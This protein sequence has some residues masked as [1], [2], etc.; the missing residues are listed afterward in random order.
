MKECQNCHAQVPEGQGGRDAEGRFI[1]CIHC[2][3]NPLGCRCEFGEFGVA[4]TRQFFQALADLAEGQIK[5]NL[6]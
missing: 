5:M 6:V 1:C 3:F 4:E 2:V